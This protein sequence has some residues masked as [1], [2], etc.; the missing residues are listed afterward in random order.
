MLQK[1]ENRRAGRAAADRR[2]RRCKVCIRSLKFKS[3][4]NKQESSLNDNVKTSV[5]LFYGFCLFTAFVYLRLL[6]IYGFSVHRF[7][8]YV[9]VSTCLLSEFQRQTQIRVPARPVVVR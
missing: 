5:E 1:N 3:P 6:S 7:R 4:N 9:M 8:N 2:A